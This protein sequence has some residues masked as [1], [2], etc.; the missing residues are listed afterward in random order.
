MGKKVFDFVRDI[1]K[2]DVLL[3]WCYFDIVVV[4]EDDDGE[5]LDVLL[6]FI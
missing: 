4:C 2:F 6:V 5:D 1:V 3:N